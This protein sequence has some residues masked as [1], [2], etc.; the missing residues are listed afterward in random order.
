[1]VSA[2][3]S[4]MQR[5]Q[6]WNDGVRD[7]VVLHDEL[8]RQ[9]WNGS[10]QTVRRYLAPLRKTDAAAQ[11]PPA[12]PKTRQVTSLLLTRPDHLQPDEQAQ[13]RLRPAPQ[14]RH[15]APS[16]TSTTKFA[17]EPVSMVL[18]SVR[19]RRR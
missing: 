14:A 13:R 19:K 1:M 6:R 16:V 3:G 5:G 9:G 11:P 12:V 4:T 7:A 8:R 17:E 15:A 2:L 18:A 10:V